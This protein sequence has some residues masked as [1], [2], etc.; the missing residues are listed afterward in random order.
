[1]GW[2]KRMR[3]LLDSIKFEH[4][5]F[6]LPFAF[7]G[8]VLG[9]HGFPSPMQCF[10][11][12]VAM[13][14]ARNSAMAFNRLV[15]ESYDARNPRTWDRALPQGLIRRRFLKGFIVVSSGV[16]IFSAFMLNHLAFILSPLALA[17]VLFY[18]Y[19]KRFT[20]LSHLI[21]GFSYTIA[22]VGAYL[23][24][25]GE[26]HRLPLLLGSGAMFWVAGFDILYA[27]LDFDFD[28]RAG[29]H[30]I[31]RHLGIG[32]ALR[33]SILFHLAA[34][35]FFVLTGFSGGMGLI[36]FGGVALVFS[37]L[38]VEHAVLSPKDLSR[39][40]F[41]FFTLNGMISVVF[42]LATFLDILGR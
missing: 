3:I 22:P 8:A 27:C 4:S 23:A 28:R 42:F 20:F 7:A 30:S 15:D 9:A 1:M 13:I 10:W 31:P 21:L 17:W 26:I 19:T 35:L 39:I 24:V 38:F 41:S 29:L 12:L 34:L 37:L 6:A 5:I 25:T 32:N 11:I 2:L 18:S 14:G 33:V 16:F 36:Y 40:N